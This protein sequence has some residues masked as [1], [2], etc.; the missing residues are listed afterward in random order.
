MD[1]S[2]LDGV[3]TFVHI[4]GLGIGE[5]S[6]YVSFR[7]EQEQPKPIDRRS[8]KAHKAYCTICRMTS[9]ARSNLLFCRSGLWLASTRVR[10]SG[11][12]SA[13][14]VSFCWIQ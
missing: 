10:F 7:A 3:E 14:S 6:D 9:L 11:S 12:A 1:S 8:V 13:V 2:R 5:S 4:K